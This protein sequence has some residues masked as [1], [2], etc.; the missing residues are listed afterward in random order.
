MSK[1]TC[2]TCT[3]Y[4]Q[5]REAVCTIIMMVFG[6]TQC[7]NFLTARVSEHWIASKNSSDNQRLPRNHINS[8]SYNIYNL[9]FLS[10]TYILINCH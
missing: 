2:T 7:D 6:M 8:V 10:I 5:S 1:D 4:L 3:E 9:V